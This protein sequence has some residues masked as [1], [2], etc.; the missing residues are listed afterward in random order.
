MPRQQKEKLIKVKSE[1]GSILPAALNKSRLA[2][3]TPAHQRGILQLLQ[4]KES[5][6][7]LLFYFVS[8]FLLHRA[9]AAQ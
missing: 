7:L 2:E 6:F 5:L 1:Q 3:K 9:H 8:P 4:L